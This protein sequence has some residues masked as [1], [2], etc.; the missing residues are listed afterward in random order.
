M[1]HHPG[2]LIATQGKL[3][4]QE[5]GGEAAFVRRHQVSGPEPNRQGEPRFVQDRS[6]RQ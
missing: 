4:L 3:P 5:Q 2:C 1:E 6:S